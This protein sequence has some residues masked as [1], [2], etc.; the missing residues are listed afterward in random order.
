MNSSQ[1]LHLRQQQFALSLEKISIFD[2]II[3]GKNI[4]LPPPF[5]VV[6][7]GL[8]CT[9]LDPMS[10]RVIFGLKTWVALQEVLAGGS[11]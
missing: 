5:Q 4:I 1:N 6:E 8:C 3:L 7:L 11:Q 9:A 2:Q 10:T